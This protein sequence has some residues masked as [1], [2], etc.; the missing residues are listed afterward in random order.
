LDISR[1]LRVLSDADWFDASR[2]RAYLIILTA[3]T[4]VGAVAYVALSP[5]VNDPFGKALGTDFASFW[6]ASKLV[7]DGAPAGPWDVAAHRAAQAALFGE[8]AGYA[9]FFY[10]PPYLLV[11]LPLAL[12]PYKA[13]L[14][15]WLA[16]TWLAWA[17]TVR[18]WM[19][20]RFSWLLVVGFP[21]VLVT[22]GHGQNAFLTAALFGAAALIA[23]RRP[24]LSGLLFGA[25]IVKPHLAL[26]VPV[27]LIL[28]GNW[29]GFL[30]A[31]AS[32]VGL[33][34]LSLLAFGPDA[35][36]AFLESSALARSAL[37][38]DLVGYAKMQS[39]YAATRL[40]GGGDALGWAMQACGLAVGVAALWIS[41][42]APEAARGAVLVC[43]TLIATPFLLDYDLTLLAIPLAWL[44]GQARQDGFRSWDKLVLTLGFLLPLIARPLAMG[45]GLP[46]APLV[47]LALLAC[48]LR[49]A[50]AVAPASTS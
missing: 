49:R 36:R 40:L 3:I 7:L 35:W 19:G 20:D 11:C 32:V 6:T 13:S 38:H 23:G 24:W 33:M 26:L 43:A 18:A 10:P 22:A 5:G 17:L 28:S 31:G 48:V 42:R 29:R 44:F 8:R 25:L 30:A 46:I 15:V 1:R 50:V 4:V 16:A 21:A 9:A 41:R 14:F 45:A 34:L 47:I 27:F 12:L 39:L 37:E 2:A